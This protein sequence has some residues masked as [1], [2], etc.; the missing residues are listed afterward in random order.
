MEACWKQYQRSLIVRS[1][2]LI[3]L[4]SYSFHENGRKAHRKLFRSAGL[5]VS[6]SEIE[7]A[8]EDS[9][10]YSRRMGNCY[11]L[12]CMWDCLLVR[13]VGSGFNRKADWDLVMVLVCG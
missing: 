12:R 13:A 4:L 6:A 8:L 11:T 10:I 2:I 7:A 5:S 9:L 3:I 1:Q